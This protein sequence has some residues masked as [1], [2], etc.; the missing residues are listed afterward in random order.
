MKKYIVMIWWNGSEPIHTRSW[1]GWISWRTKEKVSKVWGEQ[2]TKGYKESY[3]LRS[4]FTMHI[5][6]TYSLLTKIITT[7][8]D[9]TLEDPS[10]FQN[11]PI[12]QP[13]SQKPALSLFEIRLQ[14]PYA[15]LVSKIRIVIGDTLGFSFWTKAI[16]RDKT[17]KLETACAS[18]YA[19]RAAL[20]MIYIH[21][22]VGIPGK[23]PTASLSGIL[24]GTSHWRAVISVS[25]CH[26]DLSV[27]FWYPFY[28]SRLQLKHPVARSHKDLT[29]AA[30]SPV[31]SSLSLFSQ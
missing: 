17:G 2:I 15:S 10:V 13:D 7:V 18:R 9:R 27:E 3:T 19:P 23:E 4:L 24:A 25:F 21:S 8:C 31:F 26:R 12:T 5:I 14:I 1:S 22:S 28:S 29:C 11:N 6:Q 16:K 30:Y 20:N